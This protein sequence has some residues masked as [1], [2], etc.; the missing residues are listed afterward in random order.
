MSGAAVPRV[1]AQTCKRRST[2][3]TVRLNHHRASRILSR[4]ATS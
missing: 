4:P 1:G 2:E 3:R